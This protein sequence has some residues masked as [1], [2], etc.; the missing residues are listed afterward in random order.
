[1]KYIKRGSE[2][3][4]TSLQT[5]QAARITT[6]GKEKTNK[7]KKM[8]KKTKENCNV[9]DVFNQNANAN[10]EHKKNRMSWAELGWETKTIVQTYC[11]TCI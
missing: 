10:S 7:K 1:M 3:A 11:T 6:G 2:V 9:S 4:F 8:K 5:A